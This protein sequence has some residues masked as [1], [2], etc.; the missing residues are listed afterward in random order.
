MG[1]FNVIRYEHEKISHT[2]P[3]AS[4]LLEFNDCLFECGLDDMNCTGCEYTWHNK[5]DSG[6]AV[7]SKLDRV[8]INASWSRAF[9]Q[10]PA[11]FLPPG[12][13]D[14]SP[15]LVTFHGDPLPRKIFSFLNCWADHSQ[16]CN[17]VADAW[18]C[19]VAGTPNVQTH[20]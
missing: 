3:T 15:N 7:Y 4:D 10:T 16:F 13:S 1:D 2:P 12:V 20:G 6:S 19:Y 11:Q 18:R 8:L 9:A 5:Q 14:H 17:L